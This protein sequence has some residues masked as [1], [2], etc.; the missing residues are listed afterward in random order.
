MAV[1]PFVVADD[2]G[3]PPAD[4]SYELYFFPVG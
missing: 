3:R 2:H 1:R 4:G